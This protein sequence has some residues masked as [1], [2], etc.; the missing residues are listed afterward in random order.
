MVICT[1]NN[2]SSH[3]QTL[4]LNLSEA[5]FI[6][7]YD[8]VI[9][10]FAHIWKIETEPDFEGYPA[11]ERAY[12]NR[13]AGVFLLNYGKAKNLTEYQS[14]GKDLLGIADRL[15]WS[16]GEYNYSMECQMYVAIGCYN[17]GAYSEFETWLKFAEEYFSKDQLNSVYL[18]IQ[19]NLLIFQTKKFENKECTIEEVKDFTR[20]LGLRINRSADLRLQILFNNQAGIIYRL[21]ENLKK[22]ALYFQEAIKKATELNNIHFRSLITNCL[23]NTYIQMEKYE[24]AVLTV[25][26]CLELSNSDHGWRAHFLDTKTNALIF[27]SEFGDAE[28]AINEAIEI[29]IS[30]DDFGGLVEA[31]WTKMKL[32]THTGLREDA[33]DLF[34]QLYEIA[35]LRINEATATRYKKMF[36]DNVHFPVGRTLK[37]KLNS[38]ERDLVEHA[39]IEAGGK[40]EKASKLLNLKSH[41]N[42]TYLTKK[43]DFKDF[44]SERNSR[45]DKG[46]PRRK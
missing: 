20:K 40:K 26:E 13:Y 12:L 27:L 21:D 29:F 24:L 23:A 34:L 31:Y 30:G 22:S 2:I 19:I 15:F 14:R 42:M 11:L 6:R 3:F 36:Q 7:A 39:L 5:E 37:D 43:Y 9:S 33:V 41:R 44:T 32:Y 18:Q 45:K 8:K 46:L 28:A 16:C 10:L 4:L 38:V 17:E 1:T 25:D 35:K